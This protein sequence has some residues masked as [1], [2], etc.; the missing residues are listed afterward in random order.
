MIRVLIRQDFNVSLSEVSVGRLM[1]RLG[2]TPQC[3]LYR[4]WQQDPVLAKTWQETEY[5]KIAAR[6][7]KDKALIF[8]ADEAGIRSNHHAGTTWAPAGKTPVVKATGSKFGFNLISAVNAWGHFRFMT[9][10]GMVN[11]SMFKNSSNDS[12]VA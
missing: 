9:I 5:P 4:A 12:L 10:Q 1:K 2:Y 6:A 11:A 8:F 3:P 7:K